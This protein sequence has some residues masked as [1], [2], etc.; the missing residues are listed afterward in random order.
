M[1][2][3]ALSDWGAVLTAVLGDGPK[4]TEDA[5]SPTIEVGREYRLL[6]TARFSADRSD[7][8]EEGTTRV[9]VVEDADDDGDYLVMPLDGRTVGDPGDI[10][11]FVLGR[12]LVP[13]DDA[14]RPAAPNVAQ[15]A[16]EVAEEVGLITFAGRA[17]AAFADKLEGKSE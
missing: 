8:P 17:F 4:P 12:Y 7:L 15:A 6:P 2:D 10:T 3:L 9:R 16:R 11:R 1:A 5:P 14:P 13:L